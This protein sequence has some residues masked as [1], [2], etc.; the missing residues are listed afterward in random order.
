[1][2]R[3]G[4]MLTRRIEAKAK[5]QQS[6]T[7]ARLNI[8]TLMRLGACTPTRMHAFTLTELLVVIAIIAILFGLLVAFYSPSQEQRKVFEC[9]SRL[10]VI[11]RALRLYMLDWDGF[12]ASPYDS[13]DNDRDGQFDED[14]NIAGRVNGMDD[15]KD[16]RIDED[17]PDAPL[18][19][20]SNPTFL[21]LGAIKDYVRSQR[22]LVCPSDPTS[23]SP[24]GTPLPYIS[25]QVCDTGASFTPPVLPYTVSQQ[26]L[27]FQA[28]GT[29]T[30][31]ITRFLP[32]S[33]CHPSGRDD[34]NDRRADEDPIE[35]LD[36][37]GNP[38][39][40]GDDDNDGRFDEDPPNILTY[41]TDPDKLRQLAIRNISPFFPN[42]T[43]PA[44][45][46]VVTWCVHHRYVSPAAPEPNYV[47]GG[48][49]ADVVLYWDGSVHIQRMKVVP[50]P[51]PPFSN[52]C[53]DPQ[54]NW[55]RKPTEQ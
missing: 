5:G 27:C 33:D 11:H 39:N 25:Y 10:Q 45:D 3:K 9:Q 34:D 14:P 17:P 38:F 15:D 12:P 32:G 2:M 7:L 43:F 29:P 50:T 8:C 47:K 54:N 37:D 52:W 41:C 4:N 53:P 42:P 30:Y 24:L 51:C 16:G 46:T 44:D 20:P 40:D 19:N 23:F 55:R 6:H 26:S 36:N 13:L 49:P 28:G 1:M 48:I 21:G 35:D 22:A 18:D 31:A